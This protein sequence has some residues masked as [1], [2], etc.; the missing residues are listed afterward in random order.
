[1]TPQLKNKAQV[2]L[3]VFI[4]L[5]L[6]IGFQAQR[7]KQFAQKITGTE[8]WLVKLL[9]YFPFSGHPLSFTI[10]NQCHQFISDLQDE[11][12]MTTTST[13]HCEIH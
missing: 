9:L 3:I 5:I 4:P 7:G 2:L 11:K 6:K 8:L 13:M 10:Q 1:M 12:Q